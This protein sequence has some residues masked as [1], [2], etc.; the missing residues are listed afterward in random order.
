MRISIEFDVDRNEVALMSEI[1]DDS[2]MEICI[3]FTTHNADNVTVHF[4]QNGTT[5]ETVLPVAFCS[6]RYI[7]NDSIVRTAGEFTVCASGCAPLRFVVNE[8]IPAGVEYSI[9]LRGGVFYVR[10]AATSGGGDSNFGMF[11]FHIDESGHLICT[12]D[13]SDP[14]PLSIDENGHLIWNLEG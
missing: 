13:G 10:Y 1:A 4:E 6:A 12:Y 5:V 2:C 9:S 8:A 14:P 11:A 7:L 3:D